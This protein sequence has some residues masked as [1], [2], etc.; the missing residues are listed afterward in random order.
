MRAD[1]LQRAAELARRG[2][3]FVLAVV[4]WRQPPSSAQRGDS[5]LITA[6]GAFHGWLGGACT[7]PTVVREAQAA[8]ADGRP[9]LVALAPDPQ[10]A[11][12][13]GV[14]TFPM[15]CHSGGSVEIYLEPVLPAP[16]LVV[17]GVSPAARALARLGQAL[18]YAV[19]AVDPAAEAGLF[20][21]GVEVRTAMPAGGADAGAALRPRYVVVATMGEGDEEAI[22]A[23]VRLLPAYLGVVA[24]ARRF[25][26]MRR[27]LRASGV[28]EE[29]LA[30]IRSPA[31]LPLGARTPEEIALSV[32]AEIVQTRRAAEGTAAE[33][34]TPARGETSS[35]PT[36]ERRGPASLGAEQ[37]ATAPERRDPASV[38]A[39]E[40]AATTSPSAEAAPRPWESPVAP[41]VSP[42]TAVDP[43][44]GMT[45]DMARARHRAEWQGETYYFCCAGCRNKFVEAHP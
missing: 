34:T 40:K 10:S 27:A 8:L 17:F 24:S 37:K 28:A 22:A 32:L 38:G 16:E 42:A 15:T 13:P 2:E 44:C 6:D 20:G 18:G 19:T 12:R 14:S 29:A 33:G 25:G 5:A 31:G 9:R 4:T 39:R 21:D 1:L 3:P 23:A 7:R 45:V 36:P 35:P 30:S 43:V 26:E 11:G 41:S